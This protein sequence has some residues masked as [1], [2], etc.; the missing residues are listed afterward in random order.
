MQKDFLFSV[1]LFEDKVVY[2]KFCYH[3]PISRHP[4][5]CCSAAEIM[6]VLFF[7]VMKYRLDKPKD[8]ASD[9]FVM[10]KVK[11]NI[12]RLKK[13]NEAMHQFCPYTLRRVIHFSWFRGLDM[14]MADV[15]RLYQ[16][17]LIRGYSQC[18]ELPRVCPRQATFQ[19]YSWH[20]TMIEPTC[21]NVWLW[22][23]W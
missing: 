20:P 21:Q 13:N 14:Y 12:K 8:P 3:F 22:E 4:T 19:V 5:S 2:W 17:V 16:P 18:S 6:S 23:L 9:R 11:T 1:I 10:S 7:H 15:N